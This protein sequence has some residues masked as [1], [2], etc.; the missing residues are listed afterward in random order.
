M[1][2]GRIWFAHRYS[3]VLAGQPLLPGMVTDHL[4]RNRACVNPAHLE[5][6]TNRENILRGESP[7]AKNARKTHCPSGHPYDTVNT[8][9]SRKG[10]RFC[11][12]CRR[13]RDRRLRLT[14]NEPARSA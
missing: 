14:T 12:A 9:I 11:K 1:I 7:S 10:H 4:C 8:W 6:V 5:Q 3:L 2:D 13:A